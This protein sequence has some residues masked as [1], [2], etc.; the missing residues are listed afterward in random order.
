MIGVYHNKPA[1]PARLIVKK[2]PTPK[3]GF[4]IKL[5]LILLNRNQSIYL[6]IFGYID[7]C[8]SKAASKRNIGKPGHVRSSNNITLGNSFM[9]LFYFP[10]I[11]YNQCKIP[12]SILNE[13]NENRTNNQ[14]KQQDF[15]KNPLIRK[16]LIVAGIISLII[17]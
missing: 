6:L 4:G 13:K 8:L 3:F 5:P 14:Y 9:L 15:V 7:Q 16:L 2:N 1:I 17:S 11:I 12:K 10:K